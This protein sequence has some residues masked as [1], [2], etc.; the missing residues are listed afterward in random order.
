M[1]KLGEKSRLFP[2]K[3]EHDNNSERGRKYKEGRD[4][5]WWDSA[6]I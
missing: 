4:C 6:W 2:L 1:K 5:G 3:T